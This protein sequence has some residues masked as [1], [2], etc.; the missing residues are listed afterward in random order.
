MVKLKRIY[1]QPEPADGRRILVDRLWPRG[2]SKERARLD[3]WLKE[4]APS[5]ELRRW[6]GHDPDRWP[7]FRV[8]YQGELQAQGQLLQELRSIAAQETIT[9]LYAAKDQERNNAV[10]LKDLLAQ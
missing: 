2:I 9:L 3:W 4:I 7:E 6:F 10:L 8:R 1:D 5:D